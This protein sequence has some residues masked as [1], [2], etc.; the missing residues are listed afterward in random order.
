MVNQKVIEEIMGKMNLLNSLGGVINARDVFGLIDEQSSIAGKY[1]DNILAIKNSLAKLY[2]KGKILLKTPVEQTVLDMLITDYLIGLIVA[3]SGYGYVLELLEKTQRLHTSM[4]G[5][6]K[7]YS[8][9]EEYFAEV[10]AEISKMLMAAFPSINDEH[11][12]TSSY[13]PAGTDAYYYLLVNNGAG[14]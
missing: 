6:F 13:N 3:I 14:I 5:L 2:S 8:E 11:C 1:V 7:Y 4:D 9:V 12:F 10:D